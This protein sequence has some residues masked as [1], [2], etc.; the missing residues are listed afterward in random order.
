M[1]KKPDYTLRVGGERKLFIEAK[2]PCV[3]VI[4]SKDAAFQLRRYGWNAGTAVSVLTNFDK[5]IIYDCRLRPQSDDDANVSRLKVYSYEQFLQRFDE[6]YDDLSWESINS[7]QFD[8][9]FSVA[10]LRSGTEPFDKY[11]LSQIERWRES[12]ANSLAQTNPVL[13]AVELD[14]LVQR[15][16]N[17]IIFLRICEDRERISYEA[18]KAVQTY[19][20]L[21]ELFIQADR[22][23][24]SGLFDFVEDSLSLKVDVSSDLLID[25][26][27]ELYFP[28]SS[29]DFSAVETNVLG[30]IYEQFLARQIVLS[31]EGSIQFVEKPEIGQSGGVVTTPK[32]IVDQIINRTLQPL[33]EGRSPAE[34]STLRVAD[35]ACGYGVFLL[36]AYE[37]LVDYHLEWYVNDGIEKHKSH[38]LDFR[39]G[40]IRLRL[41]E[42]QR[43][44]VN[45]IYGVDID[46]QAVEIARFSLMLKTLEGENA[47]TIDTHLANSKARA[48]PNLNRNV[49]CGNS[50]VDNHSTGGTHSRISFAKGDLM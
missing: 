49:Q 39:S 17:R 10:Q 42:K 12:L 50:L 36:A 44:L 34:L 11:F 35:I 47:A 48:L 33:C 6:I 20:D 46:M 24:N 41:A 13:G 37:Y 31:D 1:S 40:Q 2:K 25:I 18:L 38:V 32:Y 27:S 23:Y 43:I 9:R 8:A 45:N 4:S 14:F 30:D 19:D 15:L 21:K 7:G 3:S 16:I 22:R 26:F 28:R 5:L 29:Y